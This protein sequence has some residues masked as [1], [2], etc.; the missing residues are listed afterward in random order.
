MDTEIENQTT[1]RDYL[2]YFIILAS[3]LIGIFWLVENIFKLVTASIE[4]DSSIFNRLFMYT[5]GTLGVVGWFFF[6]RWLFRLV[7]K[8]D[9]RKPGVPE[10]NSSSSSTSNGDKTNSSQTA[11]K[12]DSWFATKNNKTD[13]NWAPM[14][15]IAGN[16][17][18]T[19]ADV[20]GCDEAVAKL[21]RVVR[22]IKSP[23]WFVSFGAQRAN[24]VLLVGP[25]GTGKTL[26]ARALAGETD[27]NFFYVSGSE[28][29]QM[30]VGVGAQRMRKLFDQAA[31]AA[32]Q[33]HKHSII[34]IDEFDAIGR[35]RTTDESNS[36]SEYAQTINE[37]LVQ[38][39]GFSKNSNIIVVAATNLPKVLDP[40]L[41]RPG[42]FDYQAVVDLPGITGRVKVFQVHSLKLKIANDVDLLE[43]A[44]RTPGFSGAQI[45]H[46]CTEA[47]VIAA[48][49][50]EKLHAGKTA[51]EL[52]LVERTITLDDFDEAIDFVQFGDPLLARAAAMTDGDHENTAYHE[53]GHAVVQK[54]L[55]AEGANPVTKIT[56]VPRSKSLGMMQSHSLTDSYGMTE[57]QCRNHIKV[58][59]AG[60]VAQEKYLK[61][62]DTGASSDFEQASKLARAMV[63][64]WGMSP[65]GVIVTGGSLALGQEYLNEIDTQ[66]RKILEEC[67]TATREL[68]EKHTDAVV[69]VA[70]GLLQEKTILAARF[71]ELYEGRAI[72]IVEDDTED[73]ES[74]AELAL[75]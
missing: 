43:L 28:F 11:K 44:R 32:A 55:E 49:R 69:R 71:E 29:V 72:E 40:A 52:A 64:D 66:C 63:V 14:Q 22:F 6:C 34:F 46:V 9:K 36:G 31:Q 75:A 73:T 33:N 19:F 51:E 42:R 30:Y 67:M 58:L 17:K 41:L 23:D 10:S 16:D 57:T 65:M 4:A 56:I 47:A 1:G 39:D 53:A 7:G 13:D 20:A 24:G 68:I 25:P 61:T 62:K 50:S 59:L 3:I 38:M 60:R 37:M 54:A 70:N 18:K 45:A 12:P 26:L 8:G 21:A 48:E 2:R 15:H 5:L 74:G 27:S 35:K